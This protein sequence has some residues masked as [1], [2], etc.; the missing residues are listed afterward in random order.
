MI[1]VIVAD[2]AILTFVNRSWRMLYNRLAPMIDESFNRSMLHIANSV[3]LKVPYNQLFPL[4]NQT[5]P[6]E[7]TPAQTSPHPST[8]TE[9]SNTSVKTDE[10]NFTSEKPSIA[11]EAMNIKC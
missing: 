6:H 8:S 4:S 3:F 2:R 5:R 7:V 10:P 9:K 11:F 1:C